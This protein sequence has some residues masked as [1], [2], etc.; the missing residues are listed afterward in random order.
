[1][2]LQ[3]YHSIYDQLLEPRQILTSICTIGDDNTS[4][5]N[6]VGQT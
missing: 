6:A 4:L 1:M 2:F 5:F 3:G